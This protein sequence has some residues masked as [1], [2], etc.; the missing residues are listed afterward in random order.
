[1]PQA[2]LVLTIE[3]EDDEGEEGVGCIP[4]DH[5]LCQLGVMLASA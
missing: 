5:E 4:A 3:N 1:M 2:G